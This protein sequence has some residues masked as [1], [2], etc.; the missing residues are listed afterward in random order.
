MAFQKLGVVVWDYKITT[1]RISYTYEYLIQ[2]GY[3]KSKNFELQ[4]YALLP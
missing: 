2:P 4:N 3:F 1:L